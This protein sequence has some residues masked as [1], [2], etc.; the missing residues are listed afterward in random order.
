VEHRFVDAGG[1]RMHMVEAGDGA[2]L[3][4]LHGWPQHWYLWRGVIP[5]LA[6]HRRVICPDLRG[7]GW[8]DV[9]SSGYDR[10]TMARDVL[11]LLDGL[12][13][14][15]VD[16]V[17]HDWGGWIGFLLALRHPDRVRRLLALGVV[18]PWP[19]RN[20]RNL[21][22]IWRL[23]YQIPLALPWLGRLGVERGF[24]RLVLRAGSDAFSEPEMEAF[25]DRLRGER[26]R[27]SEL[28]YRT[29]LL[30]EAGPVIAGRYERLLPLRVP[31]MLVCGERDPVFSTRV[32]REQAARD[33]SLELELVP[34]VGHFLVDEK[35][36]L[37][38]DRALRFLGA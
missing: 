4:M 21:L 10:E 8:T 34:D 17:G 25:T 13:I 15:R 26:A 37:V 22:A 5:L 38:A 12:G 11:A 23:V 36:D 6:P 24:A 32:L 31:T 9:P 7:F 27:A 35:S 30:R 19:S 3:V 2:P 16:L 20:P 14:G 18:P 33:D 29:F 28:L 1:L